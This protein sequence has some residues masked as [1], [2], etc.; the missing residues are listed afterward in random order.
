MKTYKIT[1]LFLILAIAIFGCNGTDGEDGEDGAVGAN[2]VDGNANV[3]SFN[4]TI[5]GYE[6]DNSGGYYK[7]DITSSQGLV[8][9][10]DD[11]LHGALLAY[12]ET[13]AG[14]APLPYTSLLGSNATQIYRPYFDVNHFEMR[15]QNS[16]S[17]NTEPQINP[18]F[19]L[20]IVV[21]PQ[22][23]VIQDVDLNQY[24]EVKAA[25]DL[26]D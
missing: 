6:Y 8:I 25:Y 9:S 3:N 11:L 10:S 16:N 23:M 4:Y 7:T 14:W 12:I 22:G 24:E 1:Y 15:I 5:N 17:S 2:G 18:P 13:S 21:I 26:E 19:G 20:K